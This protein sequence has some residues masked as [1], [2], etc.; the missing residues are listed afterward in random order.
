M[1]WLQSNICFQVC[2]CRFSDQ[3]VR[4][5]LG[6]RCTVT[7]VLKFASAPQAV[8]AVHRRA[9]PNGKHA[10]V[11]PRLH[12]DHFA[13][14]LPPYLHQVPALQGLGDDGGDGG[15]DAA[16]DHQVFGAVADGVE[17]GPQPLGVVTLW[18]GR[19][20]E[21]EREREGRTEA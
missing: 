3:R 7:S 18:R 4:G 6:T 19:E 16:E 21:S 9:L 20:A 12:G 8:T 14:R 11:P 15:A 1:F 13:T 5:L 17:E 10:A 2:I